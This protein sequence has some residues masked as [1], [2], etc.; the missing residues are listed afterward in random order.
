MTTFIEKVTPAYMVDR[1]KE[2]CTQ[3]PD[4]RV[5]L[6]ILGE[7]R[8]LEWI[9]T[10]GVCE[11]E[12]L[13]RFIPPF[14]PLKLRQITA[15]PD[16]PE[17]LWTG[18]VDMDCIMTL[19]EKVANRVNIE[20][21]T[22]LDF[23]CGCGRMVRFLN[24]YSTSNTIHACDVNPDHVDWCRDNLHNVQLS[25]CDSLPP[26]P[27]KDQMFNLIYGLSV[28]THLSE[29]NATKWLSELNRVLKP[30]GILMVT[31]HGLT[32][33]NTI[34]N[35]TQHQEMFN[36]GPEVVTKTI[37]YFKEQ[38]FVFFKYGQNT[39]EIAKAGSEYGNTFIHPDYIYKYW[40]KEGFKVLEVIP[41][42]LRGWQDIVILQRSAK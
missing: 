24:N 39:I 42:G 37:E 26:L 23:G 11:D 22:I 29:N 40:S 1:F 15:A 32:A 35:S 7:K 25:Q 14:P 31:I 19:Y 21:P 33:L 34:N 20:H 9:Q 10:I 18:L 30:D 2:I 12:S 28:F 5:L 16:L 3:R 36:L 27:Y 6:Y 17:F 38:P 8:I 4:L 41:G 13:R